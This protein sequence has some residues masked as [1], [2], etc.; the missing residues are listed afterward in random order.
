M[1][2]GETSGICRFVMAENCGAR[3]G[4]AGRGVREVDSGSR[5]SMPSPAMAVIP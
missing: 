4:A 2:D 1:A 3:A 5:C